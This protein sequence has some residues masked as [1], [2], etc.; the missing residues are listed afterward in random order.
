MGQ[1][2]AIGRGRRD[3]V[4]DKD[5]GLDDYLKFFLS[6]IL[7]GGCCCFL[8]KL[9]FY[10]SLVLKCQGCQDANACQDTLLLPAALS[11]DISG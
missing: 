5:N 8:I 10:F 7:S 11:F 3:P 2:S 1:V 4:L 9:Y 6:L